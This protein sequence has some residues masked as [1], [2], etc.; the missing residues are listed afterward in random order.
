MKIEK[1]DPQPFG[2]SFDLKWSVETGSDLAYQL[3][4][5]GKT[6][7]HPKTAELITMKENIYGKAGY[8]EFKVRT[9]FFFF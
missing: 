3:T 6:L 7:D 5:D 9:H 8:Y 4:L 1:V 2:K